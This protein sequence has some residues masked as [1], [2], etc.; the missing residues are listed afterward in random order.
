MLRIIGPVQ[1]TKYY[2]TVQAELKHLRIVEAVDFKGYVPPNKLSEAIE[3]S[4]MHISASTCETF[5]R[6]I[7]ETLASGLPNIARKMNNAA[8]GILKD[9]PYARF[10]DDP[11]KELD[12]IEEILNNL[13]VLSSMARE[14]GNLYDE[15]VLSQLLAA[16]I[17]NQVTIGISDFDGTLFHKDDP[18]KTQRCIDA[19]RKYPKRVVCSARSIHDLLE[20]FAAYKL[21]VD[22]I[23]G[24]SGSVV[25]NGQG[26]L[27]WITP[28]DLKDI[29][30]IETLLPQIERITL[31]G[32]VLQLTVAAEKLPHIPGLHIETYQ[33]TA[34]IAHWDASKLRAVHKLLRH[35]NW[36][37]QVQV[38]G[39]G[40]YDLEL[41]DYFD[42]RIITPFPTTCHR[43][44]KEIKHDTYVL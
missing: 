16:K 19:F 35:I 1:D 44:I 26:I 5:G 10:I 11:T 31:E 14:I 15:R 33:N 34:F 21:E 6:S 30:K 3:D 40:P 25:A 13:E 29:A 22:W 42:G 43:Q 36:Q 41:I 27:L 4:H 23:V 32:K 7:F 9:L 39:D 37:G 8:A 38:F 24:Y 18:E 2:E 17:R 28:L 12:I 20:K